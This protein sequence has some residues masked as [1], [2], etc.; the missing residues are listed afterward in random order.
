MHI[1]EYSINIVDFW[2]K[3]SYKGLIVF[4]TSHKIHTSRDLTPKLG[5]TISASPGTPSNKL[6]IIS[7]DVLTGTCRFFAVLDF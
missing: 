7:R 6:K 5:A 4:S 2:K 1:Q 3:I